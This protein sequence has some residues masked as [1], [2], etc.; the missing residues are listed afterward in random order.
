MDFVCFASAYWD[1]PLWTNKQHV[2]SL[3]AA[4]GHRVLYVDPGTSW[5]ALGGW[6][7]GRYPA[8]A[9]WRWIRPERENLW[10]MLPLA[11]S[12]RQA[13]AL[14]PLTW[15]LAARAVRAFLRTQGWDQ[16][17]LWIY[18]PEAARILE[19]IPARFVCYD[20]VDDFRT[21]PQYRKRRD[22]IAA[23]EGWLLERAGLVFT[24]SPALYEIKRQQNPNTHLVPNVGD[25]EHFSRAMLPET[26]IPSDLAGIPEPR[27]GFVGAIDDYKLDVNLLAQVAASREDWSFV[28]IGPV[29]VAEKQARLQALCRPNVHLLGYRSYENLPAYLKGM[30]ACIIPYAVNEHTAS[31]FPIKF[32]EFLATDKPVIVTPLPSLLPYKDVVAVAEGPEAFARAIEDALRGDTADARAARLA[33]ARANT[34]DKRVDTLLSLVEER[35]SELEKG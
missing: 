6:L 4:R 25:Y 15:R 11:L 23:L 19:H 26:E 34:W 22:A 2:M 13:E 32:F 16:P 8:S 30:D 17:I 24:T 28:L 20:C 9:L 7:R 18:H 1:E 33:L 10:R 21:F 12:L 3:L 29:G 14:K 27:I 5:P 31:V 35:L